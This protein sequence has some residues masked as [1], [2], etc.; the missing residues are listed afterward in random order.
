M[1]TAEGQSFCVG[2]VSERE[3]K[4]VETI[5]EEHTEVMVTE[6]YLKNKNWLTPGKTMAHMRPTAQVR[7]VDTGILGSSVLATADRT[8]G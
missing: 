6:G 1:S 7:N 4:L 3:Q 2:L 8:S 5:T